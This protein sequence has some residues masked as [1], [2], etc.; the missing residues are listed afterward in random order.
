[1]EAV[2]LGIIKELEKAGA[3][4]PK[5]EKPPENIEAD[6][7]FP[8]FELAREW[9]KNPVEIAKEL[10]GKLEIKYIKEIKAV[11]PY[12]NFYV[13][14]PVYGQK[15]LESVSPE[16][17]GFILKNKKGL[18]EHTS[19]NPNAS[20][21][22]GRARNGIIGDS[23]VRVLKFYGYKIETHYYVN[24]VGKQIALLVL[25]CKN[26]KTLKF[27][28]LLKIYIKANEEMK[29]PGV[30]KKV[31]KLLADF[32]RGDKK[33][34]ASFRR[35]V[36]ICVNGQKEI[37]GKL[38]IKYNFFDYESQYLVNRRTDQ[39]LKMLEKTGRLFVDE[40]KRKVLD[41]KGF[42]IPMDPP[43][44]VLTRSD[45][46]SLYQLRDIAYTIDKIER[47]KTINVLVLGEDQKL[48]FQQLS[49]ALKIL[50]YIPP[51]V[52]HY[53]YVVLEEGKMSTRKGNVVLLEDFMKN[54]YEK[55]YNE[56]ASR[57]PKLKE[58][59]KGRRAEAVSVA[60]VRYNIVKASPEKNITFMLEEALRFDG[61]TGPYI[62]YTYARAKSIIKKS[63]GSKASKSDASHLTQ[64]QELKLL[65]Y[66]SEFPDILKK[67]A[68]DLHPHLIANFIFEI[69]T[70][71]NEFYH[72]VQV[73]TA[74]RDIK[75][76]RLTLVKAVS[77]VL[78]TGLNLLGIDVLEEM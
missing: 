78:K 77:T 22:I 45:G 8:C 10:A 25:Y 56:I 64:P 61:D 9:K 63:A 74:E 28:D 29:N 54:A 59:E 44:L 69:S 58:A 49:A 62:Q 76:A 47:G 4:N 7:S 27:S 57:Y 39:I 21:H 16:Y 31:F 52:I 75:T 68:D 24:D 34:M 14:W 38:N 37:L 53:S 2:K 36:S 23:I 17:G 33:V 50:G 26:K 42:D 73:I 55:A 60:A 3:K 71:F 11:G 66:L 12:L 13:D 72:S 46:T 19:I 30:E 65:K 40:E 70:T 67:S 15:I 6:L 43:V 5:I 48:Y 51:R 20:P 1:M 41:L 18:V 35:V 32:E